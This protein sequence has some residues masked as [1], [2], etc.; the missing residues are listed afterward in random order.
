MIITGI[1]NVLFTV[2]LLVWLVFISWW[3]VLAVV[4]ACELLRR[5]VHFIYD[6][7]GL[8]ITRAIWCGRRRRFDMQFLRDVGIR[9]L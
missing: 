4:A 8:Q 1:L 9:P 6:S 3:V 5:A 2:I 7:I